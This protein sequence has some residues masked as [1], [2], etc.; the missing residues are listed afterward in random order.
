MDMQMT[1]PDALASA[2][3]MRRI[4]P[5][6][7]WYVVASVLLA[8]AVTC[9]VLGVASFFD[10]NRQIEDFQRVSVPGQAQITFSHPGDYVLYV[11][12]PGHCCSFY[13]GGGQAPF[14]RWSMKVAMQPAGGGPLVSISTW[15]G[16]I[17]SYAVTGHQGQTA[18]YFTIRQPGKYVL[19]AS[20]VTPQSIADLAV[21]RRIGGLFIPIALIL[22]A[23]FALGPAG[24]IVG[25]VTAIRRRGHRNRPPPPWSA[26]PFLAPEPAATGWGQLP[27]PGSPAPPADY[28]ADAAATGILAA[29]DYRPR[30][31]G[32]TPLPS[33]MPPS[34]M[35]PPSPM[36]PPHPMLPPSPMLPRD[37]V[38][39]G[40]PP[41]STLLP[42]TLPSAP[43]PPAPSTMPRPP[44]AGT[45][46]PPWQVAG[47][48]AIWPPSAGLPVRHD[49]ARLPGRTRR[50]AMLLLMGAGAGIAILAGLLYLFR[51]APT[52]P[53]SAT[54][55]G[56]TAPATRPAA[57]TPSAHTRASPA[58]RSA[59][60]PTSAKGWLKGLTA[61]QARMN[62]AGPPNGVAVTP[63]ALRVTAGNLRRCTPE[64][65]G[66]G[67]PPGPL[68][69]AYNEARQACADFER[70]AKCYTAAAPVLDSAE[71][72]KLLNSCAA[73]TN[74]GSD[75]IGLA[76][77]EGSI[78]APGN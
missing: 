38:P 45:P 33:L 60:P 58:P 7:L 22:T 62:N 1:N 72:G 17:D 70:G 68:R 21:G 9:L 25:G 41:P 57:G 34:P 16:A 18:M 77:A 32:T 36:L 6:R 19:G 24:L 67:P 55:P 42:G 14:A 46:P 49:Q 69:A 56:A 31:P 4:R 2:A 12:G 23:I 73:D 27:T 35:V 10:L 51:S 71:A 47:H 53:E 48:E 13:T 63:E 8:G 5:S 43:A 64:L 59:A 54:R 37:P 20:D 28:Q 11:E 61:L 76:V 74:H 75:L 29:P 40:P 30:P 50:P 52:A 78:P 26:Q 15:R 39:P 44:S 65:A 3:S 66:L